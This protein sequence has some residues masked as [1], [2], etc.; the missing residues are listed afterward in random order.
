MPK[1]SFIEKIEVASPC[2]E[3]WEEMSGSEMVHFCSHCS[4]NVNN[5]SEMTP[6]RAAK[7]VR[8]SGGTICVRYKTHPKTGLPVFAEKMQRFARHSGV[9]AG[10]LGASLALANGTFAQ[11]GTDGTQV[12]QSD[13]S[14]KPDGAATRL[15]GYVTDPN[16]A[17]IPYALVSIINKETSEYRTATASAEGLYDFA[18]LPPGSYDVKAEA[19]G[20]DS[21]DMTDI[22]V[23][24]GSAVRRD[25]QLRLPQVSEV[26]QVGGDIEVETF[27]MGLMA[28]SESHNPLVQA[29]LNEDLEEVKA[30]ILM[31]AR[32]N[33][34]DKAYDGITPLHAAVETGNVEIAQYLL[35]RGAK[36]NGRDLLRRTPLM[37]L[38]QDASPELFQL[39]V[40]YGARV[41]LVDKER[42]TV[43]HH[44]AAYDEQTDMIRLLISYGVDVNAVNREGKTALMIAAENESE[45]NITALIQS[46]ADP[47]RAD[48]AGKTAWMLTDDARTRAVL[49][50]FGAVA[51]QN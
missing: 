46:G 10:V 8:R 12:V 18:G 48:R 45:S 36:I 35:S 34:R 19:G 25:A 30:R 26:V 22:Y 43:L 47:N 50:T 28:I 32:V 24:D 9:A 31:R 3:S 17:A 13:Q 44:F 1:K 2:T 5:I 20:F 41:N 7:L 16:G 21:R 27:T 42:N 40:T 39:L 11:S 29:V 15:S 33:V 6:L 23:S 49:E 38:D 37:M 14:V 4:K 51:M